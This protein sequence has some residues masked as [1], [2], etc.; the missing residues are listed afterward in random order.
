[1]YR[2]GP[3]TIDL[4]LLLYANES[5]ETGD[6]VVPHARM[7]ER[8]FVLEPLCELIDCDNQHPVVGVSWANLLQNVSDQDCRVFALVL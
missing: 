6:L 3:R 4:D 7:H 1:M 2:F 8:R 5:I